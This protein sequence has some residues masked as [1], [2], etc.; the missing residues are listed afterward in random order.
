MSKK[1][2]N[3][4]FE[5]LG[6][7]ELKTR[8]DGFRSKISDLQEAQSMARRELFIQSDKRRREL[9]AKCF[10]YE[11]ED[12]EEESKCVNIVNVTNVAK[13]AIGYVK[14]EQRWVSDVLVSADISCHEA[15]EDDNYYDYEERKILAGEEIP[16]AE[17]RQIFDDT[18]NFLSSRFIS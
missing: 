11:D 14:I 10:R 17:F 13:Q 15:E 3:E 9:L 4:D 1:P 5:K 18:I 6:F 2:Q 8:V 7:E 12:G 16:A